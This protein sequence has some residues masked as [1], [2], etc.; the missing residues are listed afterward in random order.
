MSVKIVMIF[1]KSTGY[2]FILCVQILA[3]K[4]Y[5]VAR[6]DVADKI[7]FNG[8]CMLGCSALG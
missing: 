4:N 7:H 8:I 5:V 6:L 2:L 1:P 3:C